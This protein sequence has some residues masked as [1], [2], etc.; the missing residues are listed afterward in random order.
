MEWWG[1]VEGGS[2]RML[3]EFRNGGRNIERNM[4]G[5]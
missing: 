4:Y 3:V 5:Y 2:R 1:K